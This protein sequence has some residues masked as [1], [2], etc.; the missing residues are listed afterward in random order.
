M[1]GADIV[2]EILKR[3]GTEIIAGFP[4]TPIIES[5]AAL[6]I[7]PILARQERVGASIADGYSRQINGKKIGVFV[8]QHGPGAENAWPGAAQ[9][10]A[11]NVPVLFL[12][13]GDALDRQSSRP[14]F[15]AAD[16]YRTVTKWSA[17]VTSAARAPSMLRRAYHL[18]RNGRPGPVLLEM[19]RDA[20]DDEFAGEIDYTPVPRHRSAPDSLDVKRAAEMIKAAKRPMIMAGQGVLWAEATPALVALAEAAN[21]PVMTTNPGKSAFPEDHALALGASLGR[22]RPAMAQAFMHAADLVIGI[23]TSLSRTNFGPVLP[24]GPKIIHATVDADDVNKDYRVD[25]ML[26][27]DAALTCA[28]LAAE[29]GKQ[30]VDDDLRAEIAGLK[31]DWLAAWEK[32]LASNE[33][34]INQY[35]VIRDMLNAVD[36]DNVVITHDSGSPREQLMPFWEARRPRSYIGWGKSTQLGHGLGLIMGAKL[37]QPEKTCINVMGDAAIG[38]VGMDLETAARLKIGILTIVFN[39]G[40]MA[41]ERDVMVLSND[42]FGTLAQHGNYCDVARALGVEAQRVENPDAFPQSFAAA[43]EATQDGTPALIEV[44]AKEG[45]DFSRF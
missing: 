40:V 35:R 5:C 45:Y 26:I 19:L 44:M 37:A 9:A 32:H 20:W 27:G 25:H 10:F 4:R 16:S 23:G 6:G 31:R 18:M 36:P 1:N 41:A 33:T 29:I 2:A 15:N 24:G 14:V 12:P 17:Q 8:S 3:E 34:P 22:S 28:A 13:G 39:N 42:T 11:E 7:R 21:L 30:P 38:M 43:L